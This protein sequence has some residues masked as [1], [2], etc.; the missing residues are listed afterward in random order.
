[1]LPFSIEFTPG[2]PAAPQLECAIQR[3]ILSGQ[4]PPG[5]VLPGWHV[6]SAELRMHPDAVRAVFAALR[7]SGWLMGDDEGPRSVLPPAELADAIRIQLIRS[8]ARALYAEARQLGVTI[9]RVRDL[10]NEEGS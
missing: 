7:S 1:M 2:R 4:L 5:S 10:L 8:K 3:A 9:E 6:V